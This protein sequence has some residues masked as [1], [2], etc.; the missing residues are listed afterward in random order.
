MR[1][2]CRCLKSDFILVVGLFASKTPW[3]DYNLYNNRIVNT[4]SI[5]SHNDDED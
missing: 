1:K 2:K 3:M 4:T 5:S